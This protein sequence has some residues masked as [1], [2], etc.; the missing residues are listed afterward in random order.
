MTIKRYLGL[1]WRSKKYYSQRQYI[2]RT[3]NNTI[4]R[5]L[6]T[7]DKLLKLLF[8]FRCDDENTVL[9]TG[10]KAIGKTD[11]VEPSIEIEGDQVVLQSPYREAELKK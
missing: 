5:R 1:I 10:F 2:K 4:H 6:L 7:D 11:I 8:N 9:A 3:R